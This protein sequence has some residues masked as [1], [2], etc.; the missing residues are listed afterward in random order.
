MVQSC[1]TLYLNV[2]FF[3]RPSNLIPVFYA[4]AKVS[5]PHTTYATTMT[6]LTQLHVDID[7]RVHRILEN[8]ADWLCSKGCDNCCRQL[9]EVPQLTLAEWDLLREGL[10]GLTPARLE[11]VSNNM[12]TLNQS[13]PITCP[14][15]DL[16]AGT[17]PVYAQRP[18][19]CR[20]YGFYVQRDKGLYCHD[21]ETRVDEGKMADVVW[22]NQDAIDQQL[23]TL[24]ETRALTD[25][26]ESWLAESK[27]EA[28]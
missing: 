23:T 5:Q 6:K 26:F 16:T 13:R 7:A 9:A 4:R 11:E 28:A 19:A 25:W 8:R 12:A 2:R 22:G 14:M 3:N 18:V 24:G 21:I 10:Q 20:T 17:C 15:L 27:Q 1:I